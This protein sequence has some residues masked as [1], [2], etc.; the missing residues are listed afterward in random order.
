M[1]GK[2]ILKVDDAEQFPEKWEE[3]RNQGIGGSDIACIMGYNKWKS[4]YT[5]WTEKTGQSQSED[6]S[7]NEFVYW[8]TV[9]EQAVANRFVE[10]TG[11]KV[12]KCGTLVPA[13]ICSINHINVAVPL[14]K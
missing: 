5:L 10:L 12:R 14:Q 7:D 4:P 3:I 9:L 2:L 1:K 6:L 11:K 13:D 8:G